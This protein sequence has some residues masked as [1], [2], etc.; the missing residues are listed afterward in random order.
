M[1]PGGERVLLAAI[2]GAHGIRG[3]VT[4]KSF[5]DNPE[6]LRSYGPFSDESGA[7]TYEL[8]AVRASGKGI[9]ARFKG[10]NDRNA[11]EA[12][13][14]AK[15]YVNRAQLPPPEEGAF[16]HIDLVGL[17]AFDRAGAAVGEVV[18]VHN[19]GAG[20]IIELRLQ[21]KSKTELIPFTDAY[22]PEVD[23][24]GRRVVVELPVEEDEPDEK[25]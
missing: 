15:L 4:I 19:F 10:V 24:A 25:E 3:E 23:I 9:V 2:L 17:P 8:S 14:G 21:G 22:V 5:A 1:K 11:A 16:Y 20:D 7:R 12:L 18:A 13:K 6:D